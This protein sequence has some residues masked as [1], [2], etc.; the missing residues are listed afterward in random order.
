MPS[1]LSPVNPT[2]LPDGSSLPENIVIIELR[3]G[4]W[5]V[6]E[7]PKD[8]AVGV[9]RGYLSAVP[10][11]A[12]RSTAVS[13]I[14]ACSTRADAVTYVARLPH[15]NPAEGPPLGEY[16]EWALAVQRVLSSSVSPAG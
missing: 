1:T 13:A 8:A 15:F 10:A 6:K 2:T 11:A 7:Q 3:T 16:R 5:M 9:I 12:V 14:G 4:L